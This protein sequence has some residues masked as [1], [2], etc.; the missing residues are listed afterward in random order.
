MIEKEYDGFV[1]DY[2]VTVDMVLLKCFFKLDTDQSEKEIR[3]L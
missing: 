3:A 1:L 2:T